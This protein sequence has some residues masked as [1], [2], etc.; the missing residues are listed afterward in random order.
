MSEF[1]FLV[2]NPGSTSTKLALYKGKSVLLNVSVHHSKEELLRFESVSDQLVFRKQLIK[3]VVIDSGFDVNQ[4]NAV[5]GRG[6]LLR[7]IPAGVYLV[8]ERMVYDLKNGICGQHA[9]NLGALIAYDFSKEY[10]HIKPY[11][12]DP[13]IVDEMDM[14]AK[15]TGIPQIKRRSI[16][17][18]LNQK[19][20]ARKYAREHNLIYEDLNLIVAHL[21]GGISV[22]AHKLGKV[23]DVNNALDGDGPFSPERAGTI[24]AGDYIDLS[25][26]KFN[27]SKEAKS[28]LFGNAGLNAY[29]G[30]TDVKKL[31]EDD[32]YEK[33][34]VFPI[35]QA[36]C[37]QVAKQI[38]AM[39][40]V[41][42]GK[43]NA[44]ILTGGLSHSNFIVD[45]ISK[46][47][48]FIASIKVY[49]GEAE[50]EALAENML[51]I[52][53]GEAKVLDYY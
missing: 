18:A 30:I 45:E 40:A 43:V 34:N 32:T 47:I 23:I 20:I 7:P 44:V 22:G 15:I 10:E 41:L 46:R 19:A 27:S 16:F 42:N 39:A 17:H 12:A 21:G 3:K 9:S 4:I 52:L 49:P 24:P 33:S 36:M 14:I 35:I 11:I 31:L 25:F 13:E 51:R 26:S 37:Y 53:S 2:V 50:M 48:A 28:L 38:G 29:F 1:I 8:N 6:G 5:M